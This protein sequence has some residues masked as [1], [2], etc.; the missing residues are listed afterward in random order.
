MVG[1][2]ILLGPQRPNQN[3]TE[4]LATVP[5]E[6]PVVAITAGWRHDEGEIEALQRAIGPTALHLP[7]YRWF[8]EILAE[9]PALAEGW[10]QRQAKIMELKALHRL[11]LHPAIEALRDVMGR[12]AAG[13]EIARPQFQW[14]LDHL[15]ELD[16]QLLDHA[17]VIARQHPEVLRPWEHPAVAAVHQRVADSFAGARAIL[18]AGGHVAVL[19]NRLEFFGVHNL[20]AQAVARGTTAIAWS[21]G[22]MCLTE[23]IVLFYDDPPDGE[24]NPELLDRGFEM[25]GS[26]VLFPHCRERLDLLDARRVSLLATRFAPDA[27]IGLENGAWLERNGDRWMNRGPAGSAVFLWPDGEVRPLA[28]PEDAA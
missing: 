14:S 13:S 24:G 20:L 5:G 21:A 19:R 25:V 9:V 2:I 17:A 12:L 22:A 3:L 7:I 1:S 23:R 4:V 6:G 27:C 11:R 15:R 28:R 26:L 10:R 16:Q 8:D 18:V